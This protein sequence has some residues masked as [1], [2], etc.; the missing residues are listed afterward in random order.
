[1]NSQ[2]PLSPTTSPQTGQAQDPLAQLQDI[3]LPA[4][5]GIWPPAW[6]WWVTAI[7]LI[8]ILAATIFFVKRKKSRNAYRSLAIA[9]LNNINLK[10]GAEQHSEYLQ[11]LSIILRRTALSGFGAGFNASLKGIEWLEWLDKQCPNT[12]HQF[13]QGVGTAL[14]TG[15]Y[16]KSPE[17]DR[18]DLHNLSLLWIKEHRNQW[19]QSKKETVNKETANKE[20]N[21]HV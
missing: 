5:I 4:E 2:D 15:P 10:Y 21:N 8:G 7:L 18:N 3:H 17:F 12:K 6:G 13:S 20:A 16:Q 14:L 11:A 1:M 9:E 19:Q